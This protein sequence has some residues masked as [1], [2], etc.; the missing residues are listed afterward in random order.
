MAKQASGILSN[1]FLEQLAGVDRRILPKLS[2]R[3]AASAGSLLP[4]ALFMATGVSQAQ[5]AV[6]EESRTEGETV[7]VA[8]LD[9]RSE[10]AEQGRTLATVVVTALPAAIEVVAMCTDWGAGGPDLQTTEFSDSPPE[11]CRAQIYRAR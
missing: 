2:L 7:Q 9:P 4:C 8:A 3:I 5:E 1:K 6:P 11:S 10:S